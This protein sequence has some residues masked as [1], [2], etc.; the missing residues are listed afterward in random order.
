MK[1]NFI[2]ALLLLLVVYLFLSNLAWL[3]FALKRVVLI[4]GVLALVAWMLWP[5]KKLVEGAR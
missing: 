2:I 5:E 3:L 4:G 1:K